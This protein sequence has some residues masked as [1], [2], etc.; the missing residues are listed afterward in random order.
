MLRLP[1]LE[2][3][4]A[5]SA[6]AAA[7]IATVL[8]WA[9]PP[10]TDFAAH[11][12]QRTLFLEHGLRLWNN[13]WYA[14]RYG[15]ITHSVLYYP[16]A[17]LLGLRLLAVA[18]VATAA[19]AFAVVVGREWGPVARWSSRTFAVVWAGIVLSAAFPFALGF[20]LAL[21]ALLSLQSGARWRFAGLAAATVAASPLAFA[22]LVLVLA[23]VGVTRRVAAVPLAVVAALV[24][25]ELV[26]WRLFPGGRYPFPVAEL[27]AACTFCVLGIALTRGVAHGRVL[28]AVFVAALVACVASFAVPSALGENIARFRFAAIPLAVL[29]VSLRAWRPRLA[30]VVVL[31]LAASWNLT[32]LA[33]DYVKGASDP[34]GSAA[35]WAPAVRY[36]TTHLAP[37]YRV[38]AVDTAGHWASV[39]LPRAGIPLTRGWYPQD[40]FPQNE[41]LY[42]EFGRRPYLRWLRKLAVRYVVVPRAPVDATAREEAELISTHR[43]GLRRVFVSPTV[44]IYTV[45]RP[46]PLVTG[47]GRAAVIRMTQ[48]RLELAVSRAGWY[49]VAVRYSPY[50]RALDACTAR[51]ADGMTEVRVSRAGVEELSFDVQAGRALGVLVGT[52]ATDSCST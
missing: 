35:F 8:V 40:D 26:V 25:A 34:S 51:S 36:L 24:A 37:S 39:Y 21:L 19:F 31:G 23:G 47:R 17:A 33:W 22:L 38:E 46:R 9:G 49:R 12:Y 1:T 52:A 41:L 11:A 16:I 14:G 27:A 29:V 30:V 20:A 44:S 4:A 13:F 45:P 42:R 50:W 6:C 18:A 5:L 28:Q 15:F 2:R 3:E 10:G 43:S 7:A 32:P 48:T